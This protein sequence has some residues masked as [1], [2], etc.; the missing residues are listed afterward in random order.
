MARTQA[1]PEEKSILATVPE[2]ADYVAAVKQR[3]RKVPGV[4]LRQLDPSAAGPLQQRR[5]TGGNGGAQEL[6]IA[7]GKPESSA[8]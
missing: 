2:I 1:H 8:S 5:T 3:S 7:T 4:A 6:K